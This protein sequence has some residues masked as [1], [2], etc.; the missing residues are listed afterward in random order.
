[1]HIRNDV[2]V[3]ELKD[4]G[5][6]LAFPTRLTV[7]ESLD[8]PSGWMRDSK[9]VLFTSDRMGRRQVFRQPMDQNTAEFLIRGPDEEEGAELSPDGR[10]ILYWSSA[11]DRDSPPTTKRLMRLPALGGSPE[12]VLEA[13]TNEGAD[14]HCP[15]GP[16]SPCA[17]SHWEKGWLIFYALDPV[18]G[19]GKELARTKLESPTYF[20][21]SVSPEGLRIAVSRQ[22]E[23]PEQIRILDLRNGTERNLQLPHGWSIWSLSWTADGK[24]LFAAAHL[25]TGYFIARIELDGKTRVLL[26]RGPNQSLD[27]LRPSPDGRHLAFS[28]R[29]WESNAWLLENF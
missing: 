9:T 18:Q 23:H 27:S 4:G 5:T 1:M 7:S 11:R 13:G 3:G 20:D 12:P 15:V 2:Y 6:R 25:S 29:T 14:F 17:L 16:A 22:D 8:S 21:W 24:S 28:Q 10:W 26:D 19:R